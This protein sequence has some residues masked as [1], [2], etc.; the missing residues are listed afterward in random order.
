MI[1]A[2]REYLPVGIFGI[3]CG[4]PFWFD[5][6]GV[7]VKILTAVILVI[8]VITMTVDHKHKLMLM[9]LKYLKIM[10]DLLDESKNGHDR[11]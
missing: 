7:E 11:R 1:K 3:V 6:V 8:Y 5:G 4:V 2:I 9:D 10:Y